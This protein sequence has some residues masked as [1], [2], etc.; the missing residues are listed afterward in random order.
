V[1]ARE[2]RLA[3]GEPGVGA[4]ACAGPDVAD[5]HGEGEPLAVHVVDEG[6]EPLHLALV[7][8]RV[9]EHAKV[10]GAGRRHVG[11]AGEQAEKEGQSLFSRCRRLCA[12]A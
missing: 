6:V 2:L 1:Q 8:W 11:A 9:A 3:R 12:G 10:K 7:V 4:G 5:V